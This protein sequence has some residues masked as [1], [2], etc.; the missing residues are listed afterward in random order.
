VINEIF[1]PSVLLY[2]A[3]KGGKAQQPMWNL[4]QGIKCEK[5]STVADP[6]FEA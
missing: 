1:P 5:Q 6:S 4:M 2:D 3:L